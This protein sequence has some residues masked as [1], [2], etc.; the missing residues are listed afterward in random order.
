M[1]QALAGPWENPK[2]T[3]HW[4]H[5][6]CVHAQQK[7]QTPKPAL[8]VGSHGVVALPLGGL[9]ARGVQHAL[10]QADALR[11]HLYQL[12][13]AH[14]ADRVLQREDARWRQEHLRCS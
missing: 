3:N 1:Q 5:E 6:T 9:A 8:A 2:G 11:R 4:L 12:I 7:M 13:P 10:A 14:V